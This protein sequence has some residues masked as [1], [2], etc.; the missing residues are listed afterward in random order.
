MVCGV[1]LVQKGEG[2]GKLYLFMDYL[3]CILKGQ[4]HSSVIW[5]QPCRPLHSTGVGPN[6]MSKHSQEET[7]LNEGFSIVK[8][9]D[10]VWALASAEEMW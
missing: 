8:S 9:T 6:Q 7:N 4:H 10:C 5:L 2:I 1:L 3:C